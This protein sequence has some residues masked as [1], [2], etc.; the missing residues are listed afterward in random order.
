MVIVVV[1]VVFV[2]VVAI[3]AHTAA[4]DPVSFF[5]AR[6]LTTPTKHQHER[7]NREKKPFK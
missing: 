4:T 2:V 7:I 6:P 1:V 3:V 5:A